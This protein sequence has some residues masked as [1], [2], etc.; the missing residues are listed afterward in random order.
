MYYFRARRSDRALAIIQNVK[1][2]VYRFRHLPS[3]ASLRKL[4]HMTLTYSFKVK[5]WYANISETVLASKCS[6]VFCRFRYLL[7][8]G[9][10]VKNYTRD[11]VLLFEDYAFGTFIYLKRYELA[12]NKS[13][14]DFCRFLYLLSNGLITKHYTR[15]LN[16]HKLETWICL[17]RWELA[18]KCIGNFRRC[19]YIPS[20][21][22]IVTF[23]FG[24]YVISYSNDQW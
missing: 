8:N 4:H 11:L 16:G 18:Q 7:S 12:L 14:D 15:N 2:N 5:K 3:N 10:S 17:K 22:L 21:D 9:V 13:G 6:D 20:N 1:N 24:C 19:W 23:S